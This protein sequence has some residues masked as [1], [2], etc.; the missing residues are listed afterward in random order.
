M[1][2]FDEFTGTVIDTMCGRIE[3]KTSEYANFIDYLEGI[4]KLSD[5]CETS[6]ETAFKI[7]IA[8]H[9]ISLL[10]SSEHITSETLFEKGIDVMCYLNLWMYYQNIVENGVE[11]P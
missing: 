3:R 6:P 11:D 7:L 5:L 9:C 8:K 10:N 2:D 1:K 4:K